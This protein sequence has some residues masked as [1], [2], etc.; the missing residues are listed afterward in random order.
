MSEQRRVRYKVSPAL[1]DGS[2]YDVFASKGDLLE[3]IKGWCSEFG[4][5]ENEGE[6]FAVEVAAM[7]D[8]EFDRLPEL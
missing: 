3:A 4:Q 8:E 6:S 2:S 7:T 5:T 1:G